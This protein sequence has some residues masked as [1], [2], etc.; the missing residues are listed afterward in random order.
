VATKTRVRVELTTEEMLVGLLLEL[1]SIREMMKLYLEFNGHT[2]YM[3]AHSSM[4][5][6]E[7]W[8]SKLKDHA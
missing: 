5:D 1:R 8:W 2:S 7:N 3:A 6:V 4:L